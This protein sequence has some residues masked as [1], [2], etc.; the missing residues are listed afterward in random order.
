MI[1]SQSGSH[2]G[3]HTLN[4]FVRA[5]FSLQLLGVIVT[6]LQRHLGLYKVQEHLCSALSN[7]SNLPDAKALVA[8]CG[9]IHALLRAATAFPGELEL[10]EIVAIA[11]RS[12]CAIGAGLSVFVSA[13]GSLFGLFY[14]P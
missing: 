14:E 7:V 2:A 10:Q 1:F 4:S 5:C 6:S 9:A 12:L 11:S 13:L 8:S 3:A